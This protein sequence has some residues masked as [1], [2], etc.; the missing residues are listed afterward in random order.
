MTGVWQKEHWLGSHSQSQAYFY[1][2]EAAG[3]TFL[4]LKTLP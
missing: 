1:W 3:L 4:S 2:S